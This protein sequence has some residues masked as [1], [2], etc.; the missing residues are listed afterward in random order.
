MLKNSKYR[1]L[2]PL[3]P[4]SVRVYMFESSTSLKCF[5]IESKIAYLITTLFDVAKA[6][7]LFSN[8]VVSN[9]LYLLFFLNQVKQEWNL[10]DSFDFSTHNISNITKHQLHL[11]LFGNEK[12]NGDRIDFH[13]NFMV[14]ADNYIQV[15]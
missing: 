8:Y 6:W 7:K 2:P 4:I 11:Q 15:I 3:V 13:N 14:I 9:N 5:K 10:M 12:I 1:Y